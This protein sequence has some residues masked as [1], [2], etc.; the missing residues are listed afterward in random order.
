MAER[1][2]LLG[3]TLGWRL[4]G[5]VPE[6]VAYGLFSAIADGLW[7]WHGSAVR[8]LEANLRRVVP[9]AGDDEIRR[10]SRAGLRSYL[11]YW[12]DVFR[13]TGWSHDRTVGTVRLVDG[14][15]LWKAWAQ[16]RGLVV[17]LAHQGNWDHAGAWSTY[18]LAKVVTVAERL[19]PAGLFNRFVAYRESLGMEILPLTGG[20]SVLPTLVRRVRAGGFV[21]LLMDRD[22]TQSGAPVQFFGETARMAVGPAALALAARVPLLP[23]NV[24]YERLP[25]GASSRWGLVIT[26]HPPV[27]VP[28]APRQVQIQQMTQAC[29]D[30]LAQG[31]RQ[32]PEDWHMLQRV[33]DADR[34]G[35]PA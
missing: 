12:C 26:M 19:K 34:E 2:T 7:W 35:Q 32:H 15:L 1:L 9:G 17:A 31:I 20:S 24:H 6:V 13:L 10:L 25:R 5:L 29:A 22:L 14:D 8:Q 30:A 27:E 3:Y 23:V 11:R 33:F 16:D 21:P 28:D 4:A 18:R